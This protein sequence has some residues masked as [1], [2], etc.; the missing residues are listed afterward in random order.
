MQ[1]YPISLSVDE[2]VMSVSE[3]NCCTSK[4]LLPSWFFLFSFVSVSER[5]ILQLYPSFLSSFQTKANLKL[6]KQ[7]LGNLFPSPIQ[8]AHLDWFIQVVVVFMQETWNCIHFVVIRAIARAIGFGPSIYPDPMRI[9]SM[10]Q[11][12][13]IWWNRMRI[14]IGRNK[15]EEK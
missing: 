11:V 9:D 5:K 4:G 13:W 8:S 12:G 10:S 6:L 2:V 3:M 14:L 15:A 1:K 7:K